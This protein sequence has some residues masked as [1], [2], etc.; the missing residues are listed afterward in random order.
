MTQARR[1]PARRRGAFEDS[2]E[3]RLDAG[4]GP[5]RPRSASRSRRRAPRPCSS[6]GLA[7][8]RS[9]GRRGPRRRRGSRPLP[10][11]REQLL[12]AQRRGRRS[13]SRP[14]PHRAGSQAHRLSARRRR[15]CRR[16][17]RIGLPRFVRGRARRLT[18]RA[19]SVELRRT[20]PRPG[21][22]GRGRA[23]ADRCAARALAATLGLERPAR[24]GG[25][26][27]ARHASGAGVSACRSLR[28]G[29]TRRVPAPDL[30]Q[31]APPPDLLHAGCAS[32]GSR[33]PRLGLGA[34][35]DDA[36]GLGAP[37]RRSRR[38]L[39]ARR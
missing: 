20:D 12:V 26:T 16:L 38:L 9:S 6:P 23:T 32:A 28:D 35:A 27:A 10:R 15:P 34:G 2:L 11:L 31:R 33:S 19:V 3:Q 18:F 13:A 8:P 21:G 4:D 1:L 7:P 14:A 25:C 22:C 37:P 29:R 39:S 30:R 17:R 24:L 5:N 36:L